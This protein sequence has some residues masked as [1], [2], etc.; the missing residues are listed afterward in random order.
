MEFILVEYTIIWKRFMQECTKSYQV[1]AVMLFFYYFYAA[2]WS[3][4]A[5]LWS[6]IIFCYLQVQT[7]GKSSKI[8]S[9]HCNVKKIIQDP[10][11]CGF[12]VLIVKQDQRRYFFHFNFTKLHKLSAPKLYGTELQTFLQKV[13][14]PKI[15]TEVQ[16][17]K[18]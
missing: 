17:P 6:S 4:Y 9:K 3:L 8:P 2:L 11:G 1:K 18:K 12:E 13:Q 15:F 5:V 14:I 10:S 7:S 16:I